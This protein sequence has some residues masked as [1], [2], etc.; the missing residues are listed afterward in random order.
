MTPGFVYPDASSSTEPDSTYRPG[1]QPMADAPPAQRRRA[2]SQ[3][4]RGMG[5]ADE[6]FRERSHTTPDG[7]R[8]STRPTTTLDIEQACRNP[9]KG[10]SS[11]AITFP[12][13]VPPLR[14]QHPIFSI[15]FAN[16]HPR[17]AFARAITVPAT[18]ALKARRA[19]RVATRDFRMFDGARESE[20]HQSWTFRMKLGPFRTAPSK[21]AADTGVWEFV[22]A[23]KLLG[24]C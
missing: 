9:L 24:I 3:K 11:Y 2:D 18:V 19:T 13:G 5:G 7:L 14:A 6:E 1:D 8:S 23:L 17:H 16:I 21:R 22:S 10:W 20:T 15:P 4:E 12:M